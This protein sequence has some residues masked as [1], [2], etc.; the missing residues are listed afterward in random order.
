MRRLLQI[1]SFLALVLT[2]PLQAQN[3]PYDDS[4]TSN[5]G[6]TVDGLP[7]ETPLDGDASSVKRKQASKPTALFRMGLK[8]GANFT[9]FQDRVCQAATTAGCQT[10]LNR[11]FNGVGFEGRVG[12][13]WDL[14]YQPIYLETEFGYLHKM[15]NLDSPL[16]VVQVQQGVFYRQRTGKDSL[17]KNGFLLALDTRIAKGVD[18]DLSF[19]V[20]PAIGLSTLVEWGAFLIQLNVYLSQIRESN[21]HWS[22]SFITG[23]RF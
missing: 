8:A 5:S 23:L 4:N 12:F 11:S 20:L 21:N 16:K 18:G 6:E 1:L 3:Y 9:S 15:I 13:G 14:A 7:V 17:W 10:Y 19:A 2:T 22:T